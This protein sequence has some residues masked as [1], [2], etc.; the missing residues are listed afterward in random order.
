MIISLAC[1][2]CVEIGTHTF[3][4]GI[5]QPL[6]HRRKDMARHHG[7]VQRLDYRHIP[8]RELLQII[9]HTGHEPAWKL[10]RRLP[11]ADHVRLGLLQIAKQIL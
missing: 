11:L 6:L 5:H 3:A 10:P 1:C 9:L 8:I 4:K 2:G 7:V